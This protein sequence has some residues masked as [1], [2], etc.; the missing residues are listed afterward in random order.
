MRTL[1][2]GALALCALAAADHGTSAFAADMAVKAPSA[3]VAAT[4]WTGL[5]LDTAVGWQQS[6]Y[7]WNYDASTLPGIA[8]FSM[9]STDAVMGGHIGYQQQFNWLVIGGEFGGSATFRN[10]FATSIPTPSPGAP[11]CAFGTGAQCQA[12]VGSVMTAGGRLGVAWKDVLIYGVGGSA[13]DASI[14]SRA[15]FNGSGIEYS[16]SRGANGYYAG[17][18]VD[19]MLTRTNVGDW[20]IG[21]EYEHIG[22]RNVQLF[23]SSNAFSPCAP[24]HNCA[25]RVIGAKEDIVWG[26]LTVKFNPLGL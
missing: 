8:P 1:L 11:P 21:V 9:S 16:S 17:G 22:L 10:R 20:I 25:E 5:Y 14:A 23:S 15:V 19:Y 6:S 13:F 2:A 24:G 12:S 7:R 4:N 3:P 26:K 18:G